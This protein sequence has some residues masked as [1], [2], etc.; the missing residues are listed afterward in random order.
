MFDSNKVEGCAVLSLTSCIQQS[1]LSANPSLSKML[2]SCRVFEMKPSE[3]RVIFFT[4]ELVKVVE[5]C[6]VSWLTGA[7][8]PK[9]YSVENINNILNV[10]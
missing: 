4:S 10:L 7:V 1:S 3:H 2:N 9:H 5:C 8:T 6:I